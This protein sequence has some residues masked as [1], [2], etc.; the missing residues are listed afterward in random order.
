[1][2][3][4]RRSALLLGLTASVVIGSSI[5]ASATFTDPVSTS[6]GTMRTVT[7][8]A[9]ASIEI[10]ESCTQVATGGYYNSYGRWVTTYTTYYNA[11]VTW[12]A[13]TTARGVTGYRVMA[14]LN[15]GTSVVMGETTAS[16]R[17]VSARVDRAYLN[18]Q[19]RLSVITLTSYGWTAETARTAV[20]SC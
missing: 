15:N 18:Y 6:T 13:S 7:V 11:T 20:L 3:R 12:P 1:V 17:T 14:H 9:P 10:D 16:N 8:A 2:N 5:P 4:L 19:P